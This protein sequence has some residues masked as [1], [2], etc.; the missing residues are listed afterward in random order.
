[1]QLHF[2]A[3]QLHFTALQLH[4]TAL[5]LHFTALQLHFTRSRGDTERDVQAIRPEDASLPTP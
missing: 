4:F 2:T 5:Q 3:L 1:L